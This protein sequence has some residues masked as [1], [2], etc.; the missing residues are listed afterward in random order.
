MMLYMDVRD[1]S[2]W[3]DRIESVLN[4]G[5]FGSARVK[6]LSDEGYAMVTH[7][8]DPSGVLWHLAQSMP[9]S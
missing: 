3:K 8:W 2:A 9:Q 1:A 7:M 5:G 6:G 4:E